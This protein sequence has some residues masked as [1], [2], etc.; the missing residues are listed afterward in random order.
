[1][2]TIP[3]NSRWHDLREV[4]KGDYG[5][6]LVD[7]YFED[8]GW[9]VYQPTTDKAHGFDRYLYKN[10]RQ[11]ALEVKTKPRCSKYPETGFDERSFQRYQKLSEENNLPVIIAFVDE[12]EKQ[13][14]G[15]WLSELNKPLP[16]AN[17]NEQDYPKV[18]GHT[19]GVKLTR[20]FPLKFMRR[21]RNLT[22][23]EVAILKSLNR[24]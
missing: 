21:F 9:I 24:S 16:T 3:K 22:D 17:P 12:L 13:I 8:M 18:V 6:K 7:D 11:I 14:Y 5:E 15:N 20:Y 23:D 1:M 10:G 2:A 19:G 4:K